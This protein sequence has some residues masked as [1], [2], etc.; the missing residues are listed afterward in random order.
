MVD[1]YKQKTRKKWVN[2]EA[3]FSAVFP[4]LRSAICSTVQWITNFFFWVCRACKK[5]SGLHLEFD[6]LQL[7]LG[8]GWVCLALPGSTQHLSAPLNLAALCPSELRTW[9]SQFSEDLWDCGLPKCQLAKSKCFC[10]LFILCTSWKPVHLASS[11][12]YLI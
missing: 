10:V 2:A 3:A 7:F 12:H 6:L 11:Y 9:I 5:F 8:Q 4:G 1:A